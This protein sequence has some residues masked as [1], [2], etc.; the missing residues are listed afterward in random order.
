MKDIQRNYSIQEQ[1]EN[2]IITLGK[3]A[4]YYQLFQVNM[5]GNEDLNNYLK[6][7]NEIAPDKLAYEMIEIDVSDEA[8]AIAYI[9]D[10]GL[11]EFKRS[12]FIKNQ[13]LV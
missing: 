6:L 10:N 12:N 4:N 9:C 8:I 3:L 1:L 5:K 13:A 7:Y 11:E 2:H